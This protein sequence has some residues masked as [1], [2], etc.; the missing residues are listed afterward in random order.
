MTLQIA[1][2]GLIVFAVAWLLEHARFAAVANLL[3]GIAVFILVAQTGVLRH[4][5]DPVGTSP[6]AT[7]RGTYLLLVLPLTLGMLLTAWRLAASRLLCQP[8][9]ASEA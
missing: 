4:P 9:S 6:S 7:L 3:L 5:L 2:A 8:G 1:A